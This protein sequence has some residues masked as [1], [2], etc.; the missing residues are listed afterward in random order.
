MLHRKR[1]RV[2]ISRLPL[3]RFKS[4]SVVPRGPH[5]EKVPNRHCR[6][7]GF[8]SASDLADGELDT[9]DTLTICL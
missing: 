3:V 6:L 8:R 2:A 1:A 7:V 5:G 9:S 4:A